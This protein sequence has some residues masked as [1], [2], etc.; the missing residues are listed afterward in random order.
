M[1]FNSQRDG[2]L[3]RVGKKGRPFLLFQFPTGWNS[4]LGVNYY[5]DYDGGFNSQRDGILRGIATYGYPIRYLFQFPTGWNSTM[6]QKI[7][8]FAQKQFQFPTGWNSTHYEIKA[9]IPK[10]VSIP[11]GM[12]FYVFSGAIRQGDH[13]TFQFPT[14]WNSTLQMIASSYS[15]DCFNSQRDGILHDEPLKDCFCKIVSI[16]NGMEFYR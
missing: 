8:N 7:D 10:W 13:D 3:P 16:P 11:N 12:E 5:T 15:S 9:L 1:R 4:T 14:G 2:I 6:L